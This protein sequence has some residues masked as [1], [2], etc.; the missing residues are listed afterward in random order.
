MGILSSGVGI[1][2]FVCI[3][4]IQH[5]IERVGWRMTY[6]IMAVFIPFV[7]ITAAILFLGMRPQTTPS[8]AGEDEP[9]ESEAVNSL[10]VD[11]EW[12][13]RSWTLRQAVVTKPFWFLSVASFFSCLTT[14]SVLAHQVAFFVDE[15]LEVLLA[16]YIAGLIGLVSIGGK[17]FWGALSDRIGRELTYTMVM[18]CSVFGILSLIL[19]PVLSSS[20]IPYLYAVFFGMG[21]AGIAVLPP[22]VTVDLFGE[23]A[24]GSIFGTIYILYTVGGAFGAWSGGFFHDHVG[25][26]IPFFIIVM[27]L[28]LF[29]CS[30]V[31]AAAPRKIRTVPGKG[32]FRLKRNPES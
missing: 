11:Q 1:G 16:S 29:A 4:L 14:H 27:A 32:G 8:D 26:Y 30:N 21:Y 25:D 24:Y 7:V 3:P 18:A 17:I 2:I 9:F 22:L 20:Y 12:T 19:F 5:L 23:R 15:G 10:S 31:W 28:A 6:R 13:S